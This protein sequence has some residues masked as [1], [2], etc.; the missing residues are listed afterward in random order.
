MVDVGPFAT[1]VPGDHG[2]C[3][4]TTLRHDNT[5]QASV[6]NAGVTTHPV[7]DALVI[8]FV[9]GGRA[10]LVHLRSNPTIT[11]VV[12]SGWQ[13]AAAEGSAELVG[14]D[15][16]HPDIDSNRLRILLRDIFVAAGGTHDDWSL[17]DR[18]MQEERRTAVLLS[19]TRVYS[20]P[21]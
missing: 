16:S 14:P 6:V 7:T 5:I 11:V 13:W 3:V 20:N 18:V 12:R 19:P 15:D 2:L 4:V 21:S 8:A 9:A 10:K 1:L 17:Y